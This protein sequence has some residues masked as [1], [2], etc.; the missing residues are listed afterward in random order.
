M[1]AYHDVRT[2][3]GEQSWNRKQ[4][5]DVGSSDQ[6]VEMPRVSADGLVDVGSVELQ[7][8]GH[9][10]IMRLIETV[11]NM[12]MSVSTTLLG[13]VSDSVG[14]LAR[15]R[16]PTRDLCNARHV[17]AKHER[18]RIYRGT[19]ERTGR[20]DDGEIQI[21]GDRMQGTLQ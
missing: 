11:K 5:V 1:H 13:F 18:K 12:L 4:E 8:P 15:C 6:G 20:I 7:P 9:A 14:L 2:T 17:L 16:R 19:V 21:S 3:D 10:L